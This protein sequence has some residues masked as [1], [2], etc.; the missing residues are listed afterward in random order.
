MITSKLEIGRLYLE[1]GDVLKAI[2]MLAPLSNE[3]LQTQKYDQ[4]LDTLQL[5]FRGYAELHDFEMIDHA[6]NLL[7]RLVDAEAIQ[8]TPKMLYTL[9]LCSSY[10]SK[11][12]QSLQL[13]QQSLTLAIKRDDQEGMSHAILG[14]AISYYHLDQLQDSL[15]E[16]YN[17]QI[18]MNILEL[19]QVRLSSQILK[20]QILRKMKKFDQALDILW[21]CYEMLKTEKNLYSYISLLYG[22]GLT[23]KEAGKIEEARSY[24]RLAKKSIDPLNLKRLSDLVDGLL[25]GL[26]EEDTMQMYDLVFNLSNHSI[27]EKKRGKVDLQNQF[28]LIDLLKLFLSKPGH[29][30]TKEQIVK[31]IWRQS[32]NPAVHDN[33]IYVTIKRLRQILE[34]NMEKPKYIF[35]SKYGYYFSK[36]VKILVE[37]NTEQMKENL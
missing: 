31:I 35:R 30:Y 6:Q 18:V 9:A 13:C 5:L 25:E 22:L 20:G 33:K 24:L 17:L 26:G 11:H 34:P 15:K 37:Q 3:L 1:R 28:I 8:L 4:Y 16:I 14:M 27:F 21:Q 32:Y 19:P 2:E 7:N 12:A 23:Y 10:R 29:S 36:D